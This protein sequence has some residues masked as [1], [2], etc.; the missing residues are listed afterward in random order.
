MKVNFSGRL[1]RCEVCHDWI[2]LPP[3]QQPVAVCPYCGAAQSS[4]Q[5]SGRD[6]PKNWIKSR[7]DDVSERDA[8]LISLRLQQFRIRKGLVPAPDGTGAA[9]LEPA[10]HAEDGVDDED[11]Y[12]APDGDFAPT[13][14]D[15]LSDHVLLGNVIVIAA[16]L[17]FAA[18]GLLSSTVALLGVL[19]GVVATGTI[20]DTW[21]HRFFH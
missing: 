8:A 2:V 9:T 4:L 15:Y 16:D 7:G 13:L 21:V 3:G 17:A 5:R 19:V 20:V 14:R 6:P 10:V 11:P 1:Q 12:P 18:F